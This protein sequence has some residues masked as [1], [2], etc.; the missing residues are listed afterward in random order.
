MYDVVIV[1]A[2]PSG[3]TLARLLPKHY[4]TLIIDKRNLNEY[5][6][7]RKKSCGGLVSPDAQRMLAK[8]DIGLGKDILVSPQLFAVK[9]IDN[10]NKLE[11][12]Y[13][14]N[15]INVDREKFDRLFINHIPKHVEQL[16]N[17]KF[18]NCTKIEK[19]YK[20]EYFD[21][22]EVKS[23]ETKM[24][25]GAD[26]GNSLLRKSLY[27]NDKVKK[28]VS[29]Q[30]WYLQDNPVNHYTAI[31]DKEISDYYFSISTTTRAPRVGEVDGCK[32]Y[33]DG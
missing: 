16:Y 24:I 30:K 18:N 8:F 17:V 29:M 11:R 6:G 15:Y 25:I 14:R 9:V 13:Q 22:N 20:F 10:D 5:P 12:F 21:D 7:K 2:G 3:S 32:R 28:Y 1:G 26:G 4:K 27:P 31:F 23:V 33:E 19:G